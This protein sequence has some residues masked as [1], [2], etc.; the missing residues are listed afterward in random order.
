VLSVFAFRSVCRVGGRRYTHTLYP[1]VP[2][3]IIIVVVLINFQSRL[4]AKDAAKDHI[5]I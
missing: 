5:V 4:L 3:H 1:R 2:E